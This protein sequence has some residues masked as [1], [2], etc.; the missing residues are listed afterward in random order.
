MLLVTKSVA[1]LLGVLQLP[2]VLLKPAL[3]EIDKTGIES[4]HGGEIWVRG[5]ILR[6]YPRQSP[7]KRERVCPYSKTE[8]TTEKAGK[9]G[10][11][12]TTTHS[13]AYI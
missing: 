8:K 2:G 11:T 13:R 10:L 3:D 5:L 1:K 9:L 6:I 4:N 12:V 7:E